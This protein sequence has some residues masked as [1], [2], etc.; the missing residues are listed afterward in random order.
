MLIENSFINTALTSLGIACSLLLAMLIIEYTI[1]G[2]L[3]NILAYT[4][5][6]IFVAVSYLLSMSI[7]STHQRRKLKIKKTNQTY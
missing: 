1:V 4:L 2:N 3:E 6:S 7:K 5:I